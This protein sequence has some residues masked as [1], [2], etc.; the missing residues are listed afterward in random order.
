MDKAFQ[1]CNLGAFQSP[2]NIYRPVISPD[3]EYPDFRYFPTSYKI[4]YNGKYVSA[5]PNDVIK[6]HFEEQSYEVKRLVI[7]TPSEHMIEGAPL[8]RKS[9]LSMV[10]LEGID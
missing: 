3:L 8:M 7:H 2:I 6:V 4:S 10:T 1:A 5:V 9:K